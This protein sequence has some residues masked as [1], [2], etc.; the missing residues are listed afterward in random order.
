[1]STRGTLALYRACQISAALRGRDYVI[2][3]DVKREALCVLPHRIILVNQSHLDNVRF[4]SN[5]LDEIPV[6][7]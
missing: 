2:P 5:L 3:E 7:L 4:L 1:M 6:P